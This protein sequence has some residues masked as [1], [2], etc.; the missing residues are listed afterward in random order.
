MIRVIILKVS[1]YLMPKVTV[2]WISDD[3][4]TK[5]K[6]SFSRLMTELLGSD[7]DY[8]MLIQHI[9]TVW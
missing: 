7:P 6:K 1:S 5:S 9:T 8:I 2:F 3:S 4:I